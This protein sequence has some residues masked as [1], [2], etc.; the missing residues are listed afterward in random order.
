MAGPD[1]DRTVGDTPSAAVRDDLAVMPPQRYRIVAQIGEGGMGRVYR[2][3]DTTLGRDVAIKLIET[4]LLQGPDHAWQRERFVREARAAARL[5]HPNIAVV[6]DVDPDA[7]WLVME[8]V[9]GDTL[10]TRA[11]GGPLA[12]EL[13]E[14]IALQILGA[15]SAAHEAGIVHRDIKPSN[16][17][18]AP[19]GSVKLLDFGVA[20]IVDVEVTNTGQQFG[21]PAYMAPEQLRGGSIDARADL[22]ALGVTLYELVTGQRS[23]SLHTIT[24]DAAA[25]LERA[26]G[27]RPRLARVIARCMQ[28]DP[29][30]RYAS[31]RDARADLVGASRRT[32]GRRALVIGAAVV[33]A[34]AASAG[35]ALTRAHNASDPRVAEAFAL[36]QRGEN[37]KALQVLAGY[38]PE[39]RD[40]PDAQTIALLAKW[41]QG[42]YLDDTTARVS[43][44]RLRPEQRAMI[45]GIDLITK[46]R[47]AEAVA[48]LEAADRET[49]NRVEIV[50]ALGEAQFHD[51]RLEEGATTLERAFAI[52]PRWE[53]ALHHVTE[54][55]LSRG[56]ITQLGPVAMALH[57]ID[58]PVGAELDCRIAIAERSYG[59]AV[60]L[61]KAALARTDL[62]KIPEL[63]LCQAEAQAL[64]GDLD[65]GM[66]TA[67]TAFELWPV[68]AHDAGGFAQY[69]EFFLYRH[70]L[71]G[72]LAFVR[73]KNTSQRAIAL[74]LWRPDAPVNQPQPAFPMT[75]M[76]P[77]GAA[78]WLLQQHVHGVDASAVY[79]TY[80]EPEVRAWGVALAAEA[81]GDR[82]TAI[83]ELRR[84]LA[85]P[86]KG[87]IR[88]LVAHRLAKLLHD[89]GDATG[90]AAACEDVIR[91]RFYV[92]YRAVLLPDC[93]AWT[94]PARP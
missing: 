55:R 60:E 3:H 62:E 92:N 32:R 11:E 5:V 43:E 64:V 74:L 21:T 29:D 93:E 36:A 58:P 2:A 77:L 80:P 88:M 83:T 39:H 27:S 45:D 25:K 59:R 46:R 34:G 9:A 41:W 23:L 44:L 31:A 57:A 1:E 47:T 28:G 76:Q 14:S 6:H 51:G 15:L 26:C 50:Y 69:A 20:R 33:F 19:D 71:D 13:V 8:L 78:T 52:D 12:P 89:S 35:Y 67:K 16:L 24:S 91:P 10:R 53:M 63:Y 90:A 94:S 7:G 22:Y 86:A 87:D 56:E 4:T 40:D 84:A 66:A 79:A 82:G 61:A 73:G 85:V 18:I 38:L 81:K 75:R 30:A 54:Y 48:V 72:Y 17:M 65:G 42:V 70:D 37:D 68:D 49:P